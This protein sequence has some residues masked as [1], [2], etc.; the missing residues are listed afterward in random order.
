M[1]ERMTVQTSLLGI[2]KKARSDKRY[3]FRNLYRELN[4]ELL[5]DSWRLLRKDAA[6]G[7]DRVSAAEYEANLEENIRQLVE[8]LKRKSYRAKLVRRQYIPK[9]D[10]GKRPLG[11]PAIEDKLLQMAVKRLLEAIYEQDFL[12]CSY[13]YRPRVGARAAVDQLK[14]ELQFGG[15]HHVAEADIKGFF[16]NLSHE[17]LMRMLGERID[18]QAILRLIKKW[19]K[20]GVLDTDGK[21]LRPE[22]GT[23]QGGIISPILANVYLHYA[24]DLWFEKV[25]QP[26]CHGAAFLVRYADDFVCGFGREEEARRFYSELEER[27]RKFGLELAKDKTRVI[28]FSR[29]RQGETSFDFL[30][31]EFRWGSDRQGQARV[32]LRTARKKFRNSIKRVAEWCK[33]NR[34]RRVK[35]QFQLLNAKLCGYYNY[36]GVRGNFDSLN[37][38][39]QLVQQLHLKWLNRRS[40]R[41]SY[42][43]A[44][45][46]MLKQHFAL[47]R[48]RIVALTNPVY[49]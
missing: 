29:Y 46:R 27:L 5:L 49:R 10:G 20:A 32:Q 23:P 36:Y 38:F 12:S 39:Y 3:R 19:L 44:G 41:Q 25:F 26:S 30:G 47:A 9:G 17:W 11:I 6:Y 24:L 7:V 4:E 1:K 35:E 21:V 13:G 33:Q 34:H 18:D 15:Y 22:G 28:P 45:Y 14:R 16:D 8:R 43:W 48:P 2:A 31:F 42:N 37:E 40:Q